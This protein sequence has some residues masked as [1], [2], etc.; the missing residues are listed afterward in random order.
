MFYCLFLLQ[1]EDGIDFL[2]MYKGGSEDS[3][4]VAKLTGTMNDAKL[5]I[6]E[7][8]LFVVFYTSNMTV[9]K[10]FHALIEEG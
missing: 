6:P 8:Q 4:M 1:L 2:S 9:S 10:G 3:E 5:S 7:N